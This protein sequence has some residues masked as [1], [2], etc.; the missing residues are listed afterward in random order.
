MHFAKS[1][2][3]TPRSFLRIAP[4]GQTSSQ[5]TVVLTI[6]LYG[7]AVMHLPHLM[8]FELSMTERPP[9]TLIAFLGQ[10][11]TQGR[12]KHPRQLEVDITRAS[13]QPLHAGPHTD[14]GALPR[15]D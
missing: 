12:A 1:I 6:A 13:G 9:V 5:G 2:S 7:Q 11:Y 10:L 4:T 3:A 8:H 14:S 15:S